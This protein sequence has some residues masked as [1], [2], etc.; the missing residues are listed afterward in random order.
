M[1]R[2]HRFKHKVLEKL[3]LFLSRTKQA[4]PKA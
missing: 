3:Q 1:P 2:R 4:I